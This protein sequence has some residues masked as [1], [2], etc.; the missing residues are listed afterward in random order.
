MDKVKVYECK[1]KTRHYP[2]D[3]P[4]SEHLEYEKGDDAYIN[5]KRRL[6]VETVPRNKARREETKRNF[7]RWYEEWFDE[8]AH[9]SIV[10]K[11]IAHKSFRKIIGMGEK[12]LPFIFREFENVPMLAWLEALEAIAAEDV[13]SKAKSF[14]EAIDLWL[15]WGQKRHFR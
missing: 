6:I 12:A 10:K 8:K 9:L 15:E 4:I 2:Q 13:A 1:V 7:Y 5:A 11:Q 14:Q 3:I